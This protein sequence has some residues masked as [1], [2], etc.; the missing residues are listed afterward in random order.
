M[1]VRC[2]TACTSYHAAQ[3]SISLV[4]CRLFILLKLGTPLNMQLNRHSLGKCSCCLFSRV[5]VFTDQRVRDCKE[6]PW[7][8]HDQCV[9]LTPTLSFSRFSFI[10]FTQNALVVFFELVQDAAAARRWI[11]RRLA[12]A[13]S[14]LYHSNRLVVML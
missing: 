3:T 1:R 11:R 4:A 7:A 10:R 14:S 2:A 13:F 5:S 6:S 9:L 12:W 8:L